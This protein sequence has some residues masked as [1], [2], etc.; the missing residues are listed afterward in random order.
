M[1][2]KLVNMS[3]K[4]IVS[5]SIERYQVERSEHNRYYDRKRQERI[6]YYEWQ[7]TKQPKLKTK[8]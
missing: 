3:Q 7:A 2:Y 6:E 1:F 8:I 5:N 4:M